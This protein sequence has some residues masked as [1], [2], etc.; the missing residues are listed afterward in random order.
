[1]VPD[2]DTRELVEHV[3]EATGR[4]RADV[5]REALQIGIEPIANEVNRRARKVRKS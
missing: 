1:V 2:Q 5:L 3:C 4:K